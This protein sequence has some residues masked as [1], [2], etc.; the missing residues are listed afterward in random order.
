MRFNLLKT[1]TLAILSTV[2]FINPS[3]A[4]DTH[5]LVPETSSVK[6]TGK[7]KV[8]EHY[9]KVKVDSGNVVFNKK[10]DISSAEI[11]IDMTEITCDDL[12]GEMNKK[13]V[14]H[15]KNEDFFHVDKHNFAH[16][17]T[18]KVEKIADSKYKLI[19]DMTIKGKTN[20]AEIIGLYTKG[21]KHHVFK[22]QMKFD[23]TEYG[24]KYGSGNFFTDLGDKMILDEVSLDFV[25]KAS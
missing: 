4:G 2:L 19:G 12:S 10:G 7:K 25:I 21:K 6:W 9:G 13:L 14:G 24:I 23:R 20:P 15:L 8:G 3:F 22:G 11:K 16:F 18:T 1:I 17:K 5:N